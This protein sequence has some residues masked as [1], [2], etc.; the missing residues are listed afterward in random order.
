MCAIL[1][2]LRIGGVSGISAVYRVGTDFDQLP[3][4]WSL[5]NGQTQKIFIVSAL[6]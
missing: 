2:F 4:S 1:W 3:T 6:H 5:G